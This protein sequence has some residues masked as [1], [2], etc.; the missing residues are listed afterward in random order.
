MCHFELF[1]AVD[2]TAGTEQGGNF[3]S[4]LQTFKESG[5][6]DAG[7]GFDHRA[8]VAQPIIAVLIKPGQVEART[9]AVSRSCIP[10]PCLNLP[11]AFNPNNRLRA[12]NISRACGAA[13]VVAKYRIYLS[14]LLTGHS[15]YLIPCAAWPMK[16]WKSGSCRNLGAASCL[17]GSGTIALFHNPE[18]RLFFTY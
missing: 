11:H 10:H 17:C 13:F 18:I 5:E 4:V 1:Q 14:R 9:Q 16:V 8:H 12:E 15:Q 6:C 3:G 7:F 2:L